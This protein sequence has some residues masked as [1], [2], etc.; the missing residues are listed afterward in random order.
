MAAT[1]PAINPVLG[2]QAVDSRDRTELTAV[3]GTVLAS[4]GL[5]PKLLVQAA[6]R[7]LRAAADGSRPAPELFATA[8]ELFASAELDGESPDEYRR[9][10]TLATGTPGPAI[11]RA[12]RGIRDQLNVIERVNRAEYPA[13]F[14]AP[15]HRTLWVPRGPLLAAIVPNNHPEP[16]VTWVRALAMGLAVLVRPGTKDPFTPSRLTAALLAAGLAPDKLAFLPADHQA[17]DHL[18]DQADLGLVYGGPAAAERYARRGDVLVR[19]PGRSKAL[20]GAGAEDDK[21]L[22]DDLVRWAS[23]DGGVRCNNIS[24]VLTSGPVRPLA[25]A[26]AERLADLPV[27]PV[28]DER[29][30]L[31]AVSVETGEAMA[32][33]LAGL[34]ADAV[35]HSGHR[36]GGAPLADPGDGTRVMRPLVVSTDRA[37]APVAGTELGFPFVVVAPWQPADGVRPLRDSLVVSLPGEHAGLADEALREPSVRKVVTGRTTP[38]AGVPE[39]PHDGSLAQFLLEPKGLVT[40]ENPD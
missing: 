2:G 19:G 31:P 13:P 35:D 36:Y 29:A 7:R 26:L 30:T 33:H 23:D 14:E 24:L 38:W 12:I 20:V 22:L 9:R 25:D 16:N 37:D 28:L 11:T 34:T 1:P 10:V 4:V 27:L 6:V 18:L 21:E 17:G 5:A 32:G 15:G 40:S 3:D 39:T 8:G